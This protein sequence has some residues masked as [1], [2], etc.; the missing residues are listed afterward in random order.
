MNEKVVDGIIVRE[1]LKD[2]WVSQQGDI[3]K[4]NVLVP[5]NNGLKPLITNRWYKPRTDKQPKRRFKIPCGEFGT[6]LRYRLVA[7]AWVP[8][9]KSGLYDQV[10][11]L[12]GDP[13]N[14]IASNLEWCDNSRNCQHA[15]DTGLNKGNQTG[16]NSMKRFTEDEELELLKEYE[17]MARGK[18]ID[19]R[20]NLAQKYN[21]S[22]SLIK[23]ALSSA[24]NK[25]GD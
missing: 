20:Y 24:R 6:I 1:V 19:R 5:R 12:D 4:E 14:D 13:T 7:M 18:G 16:T 23:S 25:L 9:P 21:V 3:W 11:H 17:S 8:N 10:N 22:V 15:W 2:I